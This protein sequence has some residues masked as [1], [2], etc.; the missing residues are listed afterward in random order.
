MIEKYTVLLQYHATIEVESMA[1]SQQQALFNAVNMAY[2]K[3]LDPVIDIERAELLDEYGNTIMELPLSD[4]QVE[5][6]IIE[7]KKIDDREKRLE[8]ERNYR[9]VRD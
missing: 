7:Y 3:G 2:F 4:E 5:E 1:D 8:H 9:K 6:W